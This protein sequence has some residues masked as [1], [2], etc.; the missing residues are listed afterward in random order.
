VALLSPAGHSTAKE[1]TMPEGAPIDEDLAIMLLAVQQ[2]DDADAPLDSNA[3]AVVLRLPLED[4]AR[5]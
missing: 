3:L 2:D 4:V 1:L 5:A